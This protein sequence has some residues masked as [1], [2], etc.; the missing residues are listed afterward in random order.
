[1]ISNRIAQNGLQWFAFWK[2]CVGYGCRDFGLRGNVAVIVYRFPQ[3]STKEGLGL[4]KLWELFLSIF[5]RHLLSAASHCLW[6]CILKVFWSFPCIHLFLYWLLVAL[7]INFCEIAGGM[8][9]LDQNQLRSVCHI[10]FVQQFYLTF[11]IKCVCFL[12]VRRNR[13]VVCWWLFAFF[14]KHNFKQFYTSVYEKEQCCL[15][16]LYV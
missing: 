10:M 11:S 9:T 8:V 5:L 3:H 1:M 14:S 12:C 16:K 7:H 15:L 2:N 13:R 6:M 4:K